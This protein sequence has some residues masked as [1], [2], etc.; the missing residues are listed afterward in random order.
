ME[1]LRH[2]RTKGAETDMFNLQP[3]RHI[4]TLPNEPAIIAV[5]K[6][7]IRVHV[8]ESELRSHRHK[9][10][11]RGMQNQARGSSELLDSV[12]QDAHRSAA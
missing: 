4:S 6:E 9:F 2:R 5:N 3:P 12:G 10:Y 11:D 1:P 8:S 7:A